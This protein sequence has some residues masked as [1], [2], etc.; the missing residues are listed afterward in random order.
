MVI[1]T[2]SVVT[3]TAMLPAYGKG[4]DGAGATIVEFGNNWITVE[5]ILESGQYSFKTGPLHSTGSDVR[6]LFPVG[7]GFDTLRSTNTGNDYTT[8]FDLV[9]SSQVIGATSATTTWNNFG[10][11]GDDFTMIQV[12]QVTGNSEATTS[13]SVTTTIINNNSGATSVEFRYFLDYQV[14]GDDGPFLLPR[15]PDSGPISTEFEWALGD[16][17][18]A[19]IDDNNTPLHPLVTGVGWGPGLVRG[20]FGSWPDM[21]STIFPYTIDPTL[22]VA[23]ENEFTDDSAVLLYFGQNSPISIPGGGQINFAFGFGP[24]QENPS[25]QPV[26]AVGG[27]LIPLDSTM[28][29]AAGAQ[30]TAAWMIPVIV[31]AIG[32]GI[33]IARKF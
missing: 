28:V 33:V 9:P 13:A 21:S 11:G 29:L 18:F 30:Y 6:M 14:N 25:P 3:S 8:D 19:L 2:L 16:F 32:I 23:D 12:I 7:T 27:N 24:N 20:V 1:F 5:L 17:E 31:S 26:S 4:Y 10:T 22:D 15:N